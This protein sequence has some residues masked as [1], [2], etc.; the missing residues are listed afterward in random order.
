MI[1]KKFPHLK[2]LVTRTPENAALWLLIVAWA[3]LS[4]VIFFSVTLAH[5]DCSAGW[6]TNEVPRNIVLQ[7]DG[8]DIAYPIRDD[9]DIWPQTEIADM[10]RRF[11]LAEPILY[12]RSGAK[13][14]HSFYQPEPLCPDFDF[15][16]GR[17]KDKEDEK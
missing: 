3:A 13:E 15:V 12:R 2:H 9:I 14:W 11:I 1:V 10:P 6:D 8:Y 16:K 7:I 5:A 4:L 17:C